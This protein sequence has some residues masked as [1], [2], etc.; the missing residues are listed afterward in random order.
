[1]NKSFD[2]KKIVNILFGVTVFILA[3]NLVVGKLIKKENQNKSE[4]NSEVIESQFKDALFNLGIKEDWIT[5]Q[6]GN[7]EPLKFSVKVPKDL[8]I[9]L[10][11]QEMNYVFNNRSVEIKSSENK[12]GGKNLLDFISGDETKIEV[13]FNYDSKV[14]RKSVRVGFLVNRF[15]VDTETDSLLLDFPENFAIVLVPSKSSA[16][17][18]KKIIQNRKEYVI[19]LDDNID[20][21][22][23][24]LKSN[25]SISRLKS[26]IRTIVGAFPQSV[27]FL[28]DNKS[29]LYNSPA[30][31]LIKEEMVKRKIRLLDKNSFNELAEANGKNINNV[32]DA[33]LNKLQG[34]EDK[35]FIVSAEDFLS[36]K[37]E[38]IKYRKL[39]Y[40]FSNPSA[41]LH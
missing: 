20:E 10:I 16:E 39:G 35:I 25:Y 1:M 2:K 27:F 33:S 30:Y 13:V 8:P 7:D 17:F 4:E 21:L 9:V 23:Y 12:I 40:R 37:P 41:L 22:E 15:S 11:L 18:V 6:K 29:D 26:A 36:L 3:A 38:I 32:F 28:I 19:Y 14:E 34:G 24:K 31:R 5:K